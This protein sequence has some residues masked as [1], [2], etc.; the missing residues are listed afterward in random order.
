[1]QTARE[2]LAKNRRDAMDIAEKVGGGRIRAQLRDAEGDLI[3]RLRMLDPGMKGTFTEQQMRAT[4][5][6]VRHVLRGL[7]PGMQRAV[8]DTGL[9]AADTAAG[10]VVTYLETVDRQF[11]GTGS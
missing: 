4:L 9:E 3:A 5:A 8:V 6:Q 1:M 7:R 10:G 11:R 2:T